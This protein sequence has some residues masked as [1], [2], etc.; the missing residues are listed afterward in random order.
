MPSHDMT[1]IGSAM[2]FSDSPSHSFGF[3]VDDF[4]HNSF[5]YQRTSNAISDFISYPTA[6]VTTGLLRVPRMHYPEIQQNLPPIPYQSIRDDPTPFPLHS[7][8]V[9]YE[10]PIASHDSTPRIQSRIFCLLLNHLCLI[11]LLFLLDFFR[12][13]LFHIPQ[14]SCQPLCS[15]E[16]NQGLGLTPSTSDLATL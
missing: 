5:C 11:L 8:I 1:Y 13:P 9:E 2:C 16:Q 10:T 12:K 3:G 14:N 4:Y 6:C 7:L 15:S